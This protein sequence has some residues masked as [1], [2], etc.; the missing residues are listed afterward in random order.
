MIDTDC[1]DAVFEDLNPAE[2]EAGAG[3]PAALPRDTRYAFAL[4]G[5]AAAELL[6]IQLAECTRLARALSDGIVAGQVPHYELGQTIHAF[7]NVVESASVIADT[8][9]VVQHG[10]PASP[11]KKAGRS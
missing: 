9:D 11:P 10:R 7:Q 4:P 6:G 5:L 1:T 8:I 2:P 3:G